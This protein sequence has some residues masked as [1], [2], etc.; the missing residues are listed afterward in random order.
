MVSMRSPVLL[1]V[2]RNSPGL[3]E[4][5]T[6]PLSL[7][8]PELLPSVKRPWVALKIVLLWRGLWCGNMLRSP[9]D[10]GR[11]RGTQGRQGDPWGPEDPRKPWEPR[12]TQGNPKAQGG[13]R[14]P[15][16]P[17]GI[18]GDPEGQRV[19]GRPSGPRGAR[20]TQGGPGGLEDPE[21]IRETQGAQGV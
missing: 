6:S 9:E 16:G 1:I 7:G 10:P 18:Q 12:E 3:P 5:S 11:P 8:F 19:P 14:D 21:R 20:E 15:G 4:L 17:K 13:P 2:F